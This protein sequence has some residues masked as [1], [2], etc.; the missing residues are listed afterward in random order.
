MEYHDG[1]Y[2]SGDRV[3]ISMGNGDGSVP[4]LPDYTGTVE[5]MLDRE[6]VLVQPDDG[7]AP[8]TIHVERL[9][10]IKKIQI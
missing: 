4:A 5:K 9:T 8:L 2:S 7:R 6:R 1:I 3:R 10:K